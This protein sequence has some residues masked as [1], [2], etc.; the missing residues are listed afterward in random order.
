MAAGTGRR[1]GGIAAVLV[2]CLALVACEAKG[3]MARVG[4]IGRLGG[5][6]HGPPRSGE[7][8][9]NV[10]QFG[11]KPGGIHS[12]TMPFQRAWVAA[13]G[14]NGF[15]R[16]V[17]PPGI[18]KVEELQFSGP[19]R[20]P[21]PMFQNLGT[22]KADTDITNY[23]DNGWI[24]FN[25]VNG[26]IVSGTGTFD[27]QG[28]SNWHYDDCKTNPGCNHL[29]PSLYIYDVHNAQF[30][31]IRLINSMG[32][33]MHISGSSN[34]RVHEVKINSPATSPNT[35]GIHISKSQGVKI[36]KTA[37]STGDDC[38]SLGQGTTGV[39]I[40]K[41][42]CGPGHGISV[43]SLGKLANEMDVAGV[44]VKNCTL[45]GT[46]NGI[47]IKTWPGSGPSRASGMLF[48]DILMNNVQNPIIIDQGYGGQSNKPPSRVQISNVIYQ[49]I[50]GTTTSPVAVNLM[51]S[52][53]A[54]CQNVRFQGINLRP[55]GKGA[56]TSACVNAQVGFTGFQNPRPC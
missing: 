17:V 11:C 50:F 18:Y 6:R 29:P 16:V 56:I 8:F 54:P 36:V 35:D 26:L 27:G 21:A 13:C 34:I 53:N 55:V 4:G 52:K 7:K 45:T 9:F 37:I 28:Q 1:A 5:H 47:R 15:A 23:Q 49:N 38:I 2:L 14:F 41:V 12:C 3:I 42:S 22:V 33:H 31:G 19:C 40:S 10:L 46:E 39:T 25:S 30:R 44:M 24:S 43:G 48:S 51:C 20:G 32:F